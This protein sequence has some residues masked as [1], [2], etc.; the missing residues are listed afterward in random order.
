MEL[1][2]RVGRVNNQHAHVEVYDQGG[3]SGALILS[4]GTFEELEEEH[5]DVFG[6]GDRVKVKVV[7]LSHEEAAEGTEPTRRQLARDESPEE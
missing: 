6:T 3:H 7:P 5:G 4:K 1:T 2:I